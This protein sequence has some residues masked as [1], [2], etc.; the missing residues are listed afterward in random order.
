[1]TINFHNRLKYYLF[2]SGNDPQVSHPLNTEAQ[3]LLLDLSEQIK[4][5]T[6]TLLDIALFK[7]ED[8]HVALRHDSK[9]RVQ[10]WLEQHLDEELDLS[11]FQMIDDIWPTGGDWSS[12]RK[13]DLVA[14]DSLALDGIL[15]ILLMFK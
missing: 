8:L 12:P 5:D 9:Q 10:A 1:M 11:M 15:S 3:T 6:N 14:I 13:Y 7:A 2:T 4:K